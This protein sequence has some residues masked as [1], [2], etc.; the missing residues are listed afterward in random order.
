MRMDCCDGATE[1]E[2][3]SH[4][5]Q[6]GGV[7]VSQSSNPQS[8]HAHARFLLFPLIRLTIND[9]RDDQYLNSSFRS[10]KRSEWDDD[11]WSVRGATF[12]DESRLM[13]IATDVLLTVFDGVHPRLG[14]ESRNMVSHGGRHVGCRD[15]SRSNGIPTTLQRLQRVISPVPRAP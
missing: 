6:C 9:C 3:P 15:V 7:T 1:K 14:T 13:G 11:A 4:K 2:L 12:W 10:Q 8:S 5:S